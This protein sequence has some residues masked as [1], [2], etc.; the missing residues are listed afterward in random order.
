MIVGVED[1][2]DGVHLWGAELGL[3]GKSH[4][5]LSHEVGPS[6]LT[7]A[8]GELVEAAAQWWYWSR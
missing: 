3:G 6:S 4:L 2:S 7:Q 8:G 5:S 1:P